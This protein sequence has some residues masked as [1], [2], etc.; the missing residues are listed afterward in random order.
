MLLSLR[1]V[2]ALSGLLI[3]RIGLLLVALPWLLRL[4]LRCAVHGGLLLPTRRLL[5]ACGF[6]L[7][8][9]V[10]FPLVEHLLLGLI[11]LSRLL[12][13]TAELRGQLAYIQPE[14]QR[15]AGQ[16]PHDRHNA[17]A[18]YVQRLPQGPAEQHSQQTAAH[19]AVYTGIVGLCQKGL[20]RIR[21]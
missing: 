17:S 6:L 9:V 8:H 19:V 21:G 4:L 10:H 16:N 11:R 15:T 2:I 14:Q 5:L 1:R 13:V 12:L 20:I 18:H 3:R 7:Q